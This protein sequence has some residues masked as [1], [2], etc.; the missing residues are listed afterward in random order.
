MNTTQ[1]N[2]SESQYIRE[3]HPKSMIFLHHTAGNANAAGVYKFWETNPERIG[4]CVVIAG[5]PKR[6]DNFQDGE[7]VQ[8]YSSKY[9]AYHL[10]LRESTFHNFGIAYK[11]LDRI[12]IAVE[13]C[14]W[15]QLAYRNSKFYTCGNTVLDEKDVIALDHPHRGYKYYHNYTDKQIDSLEKLLR[16]WKTKYNIP[17]NYSDDIFDVCPRALR[18]EPGVYTHNSVR[19][20]KT[21]IYPHPKL[22]EM[23]K[24]L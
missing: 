21:D 24:S 1:Y 19:Y 17:V 13:L 4:T 23:L 2:F 16:Y 11:S 9:W 15:G 10:G 20:D 18:G 5:T 8:G 3:E 22:V 12:S 6:T 7:I 14:N